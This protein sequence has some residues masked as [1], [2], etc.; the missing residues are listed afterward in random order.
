MLN[1]L[2]TQ[3]ELP[4]PF[5]LELGRRIR[6][7]R[8]AQGWT[9]AQLAEAVEMRRPTLTHME[10]GKVLPDIVTLLLLAAHLQQPLAAL[11]PEPF[12]EAQLEEDASLEELQLLLQFRRIHRK[13]FQHLVIQQVKAV[14]NYERGLEASGEEDGGA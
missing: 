1:S 2:S 12:Q 6:R 5:S 3:A 10:A 8:T 11:L 14:A 13:T 9:Q 4:T 7:A